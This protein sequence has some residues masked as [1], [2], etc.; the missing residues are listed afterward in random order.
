MFV[1]DDYYSHV[2]GET[3]AANSYLVKVKEKSDIANVASKF[4]NL[5]GVKGVA[6]NLNII[7]QVRGVSKSLLT[8]M[9]VLTIM[10]TQLA[11]VILYNLT[12][13]NMVERV[14]E[15][16]LQLR[17]SDFLT[18]KQLCT[19]TVKLSFCQLSVLF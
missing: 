3:P 8:V 2:W 18:K 16:Y 11:I 10:S 5:E 19:Y 15:R 6:H 14:R 7:E 12:N 17:Y 13:I 9:F 1:S 4:M